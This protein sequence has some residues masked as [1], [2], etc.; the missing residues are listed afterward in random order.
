MTESPLLVEKLKLPPAYE[1]LLN[2][3]HA[4]YRACRDGRGSGK[5]HS[6]ASALILR[7]L[8]RTT[9]T[10]SAL[11]VQNSLRDS[12][13][14]L[15]NDKIDGADLRNFFHSTDAEIRGRN[16]SLF[17]FAGLR[18]NPETI[19]SLEGADIVWVEEAD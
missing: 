6:F 11:E 15:L 12:S 19:K 18:T 7:T 4:R 5:S 8:Q 16:G 1:F 17:I 9:R 10:L 3:Q 14:R 2:P 13:W